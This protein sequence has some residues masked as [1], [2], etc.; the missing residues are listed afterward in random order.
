MKNKLRYRIALHYCISLIFFRPM[1]NKYGVLIVRTMRATARAVTAYYVTTDKF[2]ISFT[3]GSLYHCQYHDA[4]LIGRLEGNQFSSK[5]LRRARYTNQEAN[6]FLSRSYT[7]DRFIPILVGG[8]I[9]M[10]AKFSN[11]LI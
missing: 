11:K 1:P 7:I 4:E 8:R 9:Y 6:S 5:M 2:S 3:R 10:Y